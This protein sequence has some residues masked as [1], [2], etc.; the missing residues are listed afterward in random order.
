[1]TR[2][3]KVGYNLLIMKEIWSKPIFGIALLSLVRC[4]RR[5]TTLGEGIQIVPKCQIDRTANGL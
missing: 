1:M 4:K 5:F 3:V 2:Q